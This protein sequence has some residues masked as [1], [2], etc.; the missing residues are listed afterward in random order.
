MAARRGRLAGLP[1]ATSIRACGSPAHA[2]PRG[3]LLYPRLSRDELEGRFV[4]PMAY[5]DP[6]GERNN[7]MS[8]KRRSGSDVRAEASRDPRDMAKAELLEAQSPDD[9]R[10][11]PPERHPRPAPCPATASRVR[12]SQPSGHGALP[13]E[14]NQG[15]DWDAYV[16]LGRTTATNAGSPTGREPHGHG[17]PIVVVRV[18]PHQGGRESRPQGQGAQA[19]GC[20]KTGRYA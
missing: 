5:P 16:M 3:A 12:R 1:P 2:A 19:T 9:E 14:G 10:E 17:V 6:K 11:R 18:T 4:G 13:N 8:G 7:R 20:L 15:D